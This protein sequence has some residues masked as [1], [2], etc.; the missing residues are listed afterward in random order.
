MR[1]LW[2][3]TGILAA[4]VV[5]GLLA[6]AAPRTP[7]ADAVIAPAQTA[8]PSPI[9][10]TMVVRLPLVG[11]HATA[12]PTQTPV[13][14]PTQTPVATLGPAGIARLP[15]GYLGFSDASTHQVL[16]T[17]DDRVYIFAAEIYKPYIRALR[18]SDAGTPTGFAEVDQAHRATAASAIWSVD[19][20]ID[21]NDTVHVLYIAEG[22]PVVYQTFDARTDRW[23]QVV[24]VATSAWPNRNSGMRQ[25]SEGIALAI[26]ANGVAYAVY[27]KTQ[28]NLR[29]LYYNTNAGGS[30]NHEHLVD[31]QP[32]ADN[33]HPALAFGADGTLY[34]AWLV[35]DGAKGAIRAR[36]LRAGTWGTA[37][38]VDGNVFRDNQY[39]IDQG[40]SLLVTADGK[41]HVAYIGPYEPVAGSPSGFDYGRLHHKYSGDGG[42]N[43]V[44]DDPPARY[45]HA[46]ALAADPQGN[47]YV[48][49]HREYWKAEHCADILVTAQPAG[50]AWGTWKVFDSGC[51]DSSVSVKWSQYNWHHSVALDIIYWTEKG[52]QSQ[53]DYNELHYGEVRGGLAAID[54]LNPAGGP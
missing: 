52:P 13:A 49:G 1:R 16:R 15:T 53:N 28:G 44:G 31:D 26:D 14:T 9:N 32:N 34:A 4:L 22:G 12:A 54:S 51:Y 19:T 39:S 2:A 7:T 29:R 37:S 38:L 42:S 41:I 20:A 3:I 18:A 25:G 5:V 23:G 46:P 11:K 45:T 35:D 50:S 24:T 48:F 6:W 30:W 27:S 43:W 17:S 33:S 21:A 47:L 40:P 10:P 36:A 8:T